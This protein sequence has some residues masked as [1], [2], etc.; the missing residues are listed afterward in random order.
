MGLKATMLPHPNAKNF[1][2]YKKH[3]RLVKNSLTA[4]ILI[5]ICSTVK[6]AMGD[7]CGRR[8]PTIPD[9]LLKARMRF[10]R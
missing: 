7:L 9:R 10:Q 6:A 4:E 1:K 8:P 2:I 3:K 5:V